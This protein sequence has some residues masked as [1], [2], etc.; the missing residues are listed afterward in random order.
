[1]S[2]PP[3]RDGPILVVDDDRDVRE[4]LRDVLAD[5]GFQTAEACDGREALVYLREHAARCPLVLVDWNMPEMDAPA[6]LAALAK[7]PSIP[8]PPM[9]LL[10]ADSRML[11]QASPGDYVAL[12]KKPVNL[13]KLFEL[14]RRFQPGAAVDPS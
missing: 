7:E 1:M 2:E 10:T 9:I 11:E 6:L 8:R 4:S 13:G 14:V 3:L 12:M 5:E